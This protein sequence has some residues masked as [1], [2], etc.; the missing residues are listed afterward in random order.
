M[1]RAN[2]LVSAVVRTSPGDNRRTT[3]G[4]V[5]PHVSASEILPG[6]RLPFTSLYASCPHMDH[7]V[8]PYYC[9]GSTGCIPFPKGQVS[10]YGAVITMV[11]SLKSLGSLP[12]ANA[13]PSTRTV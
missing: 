9:V 3:L 5:I 13:T 1:L 6:T 8:D 2:R 11:E 12:C 7:P 10:S 4:M